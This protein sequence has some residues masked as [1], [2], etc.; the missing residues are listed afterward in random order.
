MSD[1]QEKKDFIRDINAEMKRAFIDYAMSVIMSRA[2][3]DVR[4]GLKPVHRRILHAMNEMGMG[5]DKSYKK[6]ARVVGEVLGKYHPHGDQA[7]YDSLV[8]MAQDFSLRYPLIAGQGNFGSIDGDSAA[9]M[10]YCITGDSLV[11]TDQGLQE[12]KDMSYGE[13]TEINTS[14]L[15]YQ[16]DKKQAVRFFNSGKHPTIRL[17]T[18]QGYEIEGSYNHPILTWSYDYGIPHIKWKSLENITPKDF[19]VLS[20]KSFFF[21]KK[22]LPLQKY[23]PQISKKARDF[24]L[25]EKMNAELA[26]LLGALVSEGSFHNGQILFNNADKEFYSKVKDAVLSQFNGVKI[27]E[28]KLKRCGCVEFSLYYKKIIDF[29]VNI[30]L[31]PVKSKDKEIPFTI[32]QSK[33]EYI[34]SFLSGLFEG[35]GSVIYKKD[36][37]HDGK[38]IELTYNSKSKKLIIQL[39]TILLN[40][41]IVTTSPYVDKRN[42]CYK[43]IISD[44]S[45]I[46]RFKDMID[47]SCS[48]KRS[49]LKKVETLNSERMSKND[50]IPFLD[51][52]LRSKYRNEFLERNNFNR[53][54]KLEK[55]Y[56]KISE[57]ID[58]RDKNVINEIVQQKY[59]FN[60]VKK[61]QRTN[62]EKNVYSLRVNSPCHSYIANGF[63]NHNTEV[64]MGKIS[65]LMLDNIEKETVEWRDNF[66]GSLKEPDVLPATLPNLLVNGSSGIAVGMATNMAPHNLCEIVDGIMKVIDNPEVSTADL[67]EVIKGPDFPTGG[68]IYGRGGILN[69]YSTGR[70]LIKVRA[71]TSVEG[72]EKKKIIVHELP[73]MVNKSELL[74]NIVELIKEK[75]VE[76]ISDLRD[77]SDRKGMRI[78]ME[79][80]RDAIEDVVL[81]Q[82]FEHTQMQSSFGILNLAIVKGEPKVLTL[83]ELIQQYIEF[84]I[85]IITKRTTYD[86]K[87]AKEKMHILE[88]LMIAVK[89]IDEVIKIIRSSKE[90]DEA[91][92]RL[93]TRFKL[94]EIQAK[95]ILDMRLQKLTGMEI[96]ALQKEHAETKKLIEQ[97]EDLLKD[98]QKILNE[99]KRELLELKDKFGDAR[100]TQIIEGEA[101][102]EIEDLIPKQ[103][104][105]ITITDSG[106]IKRIPVE[107]YHTQHRGGK[108][109]IGMETKEEDIVVDL[110][111]TSTHDYIM[112]FTNFGK[113]FWLKGYKI[114]EGSRH[115][116]G[117]AIINLLPRLEEG[118]QVET[119][120]PVHE[121]DDQ[122]Y[123]V[124]VTKKGLIKKTVLSEYS[125]IRVNGIRAIKLE[126]GDELISTKMSDGKQV[127]MIATANGQACRFNEKEV[128]AMGRVTRG[129]IG[130]RL[131]KKDKVVSMDVVEGKGDLLTITENGFGKRSAIQDYRMT[132]RGSKGVRTIVTNERNGQVIFVREV[133]DKDELII[134]SKNGMV[135]RIPIVD[136]RQQGRNTMGVRIMRLNEGDKVV[137][138][139]KIIK[140]DENI[141]EEPKE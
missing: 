39:K 124:F 21:N 104:V 35:D 88:G 14:I 50:F 57:I 131:N 17:V 82:L 112:F 133:T 20:R 63:I 4:D 113:A 85:E 80:K 125:N 99:I 105:V 84:R 116:K 98:K 91:K 27:Y 71:K 45:N 13:D 5:Y 108:G 10:R 94:S 2:L 106:Y 25:P 53:Y 110:F 128:R 42:R 79:L 122:H 87:K 93:M 70:G 92:N 64:K 117:K 31:K 134:T 81:N 120:I 18:E 7:V 36:K 76:G 65:K 6:S 32:L 74:Q 46:K 132:H 62:R 22:E 38:T 73:Y 135:V 44:V 95:A 90:V 100:R 55:N 129:V 56:K 68:I 30:G 1:E 48:R 16:H 137:S 49:V 102:I 43:L 40:F 9:A 47:F 54:N 123:L 107:T 29:L 103:D 19:V 140:S 69:A 136:I 83:K 86:L 121:F 111:V 78:V 72:E 138:V 52:Y 109:L 139:A 101:G 34:A 75:K 41:G 28:R 127:I 141:C 24:I 130:I 77:E 96:E 118:E 67:M 60:K 59:L 126:D 115:A 114:P 89:N 12:I 3:P 26:F 8:R 97:L 33:Q 66:D 23:H 11:L 58:T 37:R 119:A 15:N 61:I 51:E